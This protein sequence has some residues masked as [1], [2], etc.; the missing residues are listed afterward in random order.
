MWADPSAHQGEEYRQE[1]LKGVAEDMAKVVGLDES[2]QVPAGSYSGCLKT[3]EHTPLESGSTEFKCYCEGAGTV[4]E[5]SGSGGQR[6]ELQAV[7]G[8]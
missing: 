8:P 3:D 1:Y 4:L 7:T 6:N 2:V 5:P